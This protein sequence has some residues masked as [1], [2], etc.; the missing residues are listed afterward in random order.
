MGRSVM[1][2]KTQQSS[3]VTGVMLPCNVGA[4]IDFGAVYSALG[5]V[6]DA[7]PERTLFSFNLTPGQVTSLQ[8]LQHW[9]GSKS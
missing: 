3:L 6:G 1:C 5:E 7:A 8:C 4:R 9:S 2:T